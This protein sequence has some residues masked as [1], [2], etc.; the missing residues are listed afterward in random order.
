MIAGAGGGVVF[1]VA[2]LVGC[3]PDD[4]DDDEPADDAPAP[5]SPEDCPGSG[6]AAAAALLGCFPD[7]GL[8]VGGALVAGSCPGS[9]LAAA[10]A[11]PRLAVR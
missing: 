2:G 10:A 8:A 7:A 4:P 3:P 6:L 5:L 1:D 9:G 11:P